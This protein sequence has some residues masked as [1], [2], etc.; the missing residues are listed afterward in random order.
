MARGLYSTANHFVYSGGLITAVPLTMA[1][2]INPANITNSNLIT[3]L[4]YTSGANAELDGWRLGYVHTT[5]YPNAYVGNGTTS[6]Q[7]VHTTAVS[8]GVWNHVAAV[9]GSATSRYVYLNGIASA[10][11]TTNL[12]PSATVNKSVIL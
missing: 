1:A 11:N 10:Q 5:G 2:W 12:T 6:S 8:T 9:Y 7:A 3:G 4:F